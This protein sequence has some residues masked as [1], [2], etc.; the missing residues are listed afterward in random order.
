MWCVC[1][2]CVCDV[3]DICGVCVMSVCDMHVMCDMC[4]TIYSHED[5]LDNNYNTLVTSLQC[6]IKFLTLFFLPTFFDPTKIFF[7]RLSMSG[8]SLSLSWILGRVWCEML[9]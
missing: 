9:F 8:F 5:S 2:V 3:C 1:D 4:I 7:C 6:Y